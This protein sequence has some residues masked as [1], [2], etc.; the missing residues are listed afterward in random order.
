MSVD[1]EKINVL[2]WQDALA[3]TGDVQKAMAR[4]I[5]LK[6]FPPFK[7]FLL[8][9]T[10]RAT[11]FFRNSGGIDRTDESG[12]EL[13]DTIYKRNSWQRSGP[14]GARMHPVRSHLGKLRILDGLVALDFTIESSRG[15]HVIPFEELNKH[16]LSKTFSEE[17][18]FSVILDIDIR[19]SWKEIEQD[20]Q[21][22]WELGRTI[23]GISTERRGKPLGIEVKEEDLDLFLLWL[24]GANATD[25]KILEMY[26][27][28]HVNKLDESLL[29]DFRKRG[30]AIR[31]FID[32]M[33]VAAEWKPPVS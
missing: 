15:V 4:R 6:Q 14:W 11:T 9:E 22:R 27:R 20:I 2:E 26:K 7:D 8:A 32:P 17:N 19:T 25:E 5:L 33:G 18:P 21:A 13:L 10:E 29:L 31:D 23:H 3:S 28:H 24:S 12:N 1:N 30:P 16:S